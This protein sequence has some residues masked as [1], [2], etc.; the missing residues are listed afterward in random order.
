MRWSIK[1]VMIIRK[2]KT[3]FAKSVLGNLSLRNNEIALKKN[4]NTN[5][6]YIIKRWYYSSYSFPFLQSNAISL[7]N[8]SSDFLDFLNMWY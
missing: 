8:S 5:G 6:H 2:N 4:N 3:N 1:S 7:F